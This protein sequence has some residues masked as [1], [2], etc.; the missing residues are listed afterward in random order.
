M[1]RIRVRAEETAMAIY[2]KLRRLRRAIERRFRPG[3][4]AVAATV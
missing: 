2:F 1:N 3:C 4:H